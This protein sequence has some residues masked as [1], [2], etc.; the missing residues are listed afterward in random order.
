MDQITSKL[1]S[2]PKMVLGGLALVAVL[3]LWSIMRDDTDEKRGGSSKGTLVILILFLSG[4]YYMY[5]KGSLSNTR[6]TI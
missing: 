4:G 2:N 1:K 5:N 3:L 6:L